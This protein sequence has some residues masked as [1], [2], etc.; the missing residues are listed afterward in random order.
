[1]GDLVGTE[2]KKDG[3]ERASCT[4]LT[5]CRGFESIYFGPS[6]E[7]YIEGEEEREKERHHV[8]DQRATRTQES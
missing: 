2:G 8:E 1:M 5:F 3:K 7:V 4:L 6:P